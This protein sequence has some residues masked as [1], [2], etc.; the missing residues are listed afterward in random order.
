MAK[1]YEEVFY[2]AKLWP[3]NLT[4][5]AF[6]AGMSFHAIPDHAT[7]YSSEEEALEVLNEL[8]TQHPHLSIVKVYKQR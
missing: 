1:N 5:H 4:T 6:Y 2:V 3:H 7:E 8:I